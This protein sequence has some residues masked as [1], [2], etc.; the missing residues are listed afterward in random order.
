MVAG[1]HRSRQCESCGSKPKQGLN[2]VFLDCAQKKRLGWN[3]V[4]GGTARQTSIEKQRFGRP[5]SA[6]EV[7]PIDSSR[8]SVNARASCPKEL[9][10]RRADEGKNKVRQLEG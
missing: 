3:E 9:R 7:A 8:A 6:S 1:Y 5:L 4:R 2:F 10:F